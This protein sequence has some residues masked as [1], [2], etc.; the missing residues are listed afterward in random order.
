MGVFGRQ[1]TIT[2][3]RGEERVDNEFSFHV[4]WQKDN[5]RKNSCDKNMRKNFAPRQM[6]TINALK[7]K[8]L[9]ESVFRQVTKVAQDHK[10][11]HCF[12][13]K[14]TRDMRKSD[15][16][17]I[18]IMGRPEFVTMENKVNSKRNSFYP[19]DRV[20]QMIPDYDHRFY[21]VTEAQKCHHLLNAF[22]SKWPIIKINL[23]PEEEWACNSLN[24][25][26]SIKLNK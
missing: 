16:A 18:D 1:K 26:W 2:Q 13:K 19:P 10:D 17:L 22:A 15:G 20:K 5:P 14:K 6:D 11:I 7:A 4:S 25:Q 21:S 9:N 24:I 3:P 8:K 23:Y 12:D